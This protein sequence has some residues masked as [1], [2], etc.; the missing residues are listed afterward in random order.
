MALVFDSEMFIFP[1]EKKFDF[2]GMIRNRYNLLKFL[3]KHGVKYKDFLLI[4][5]EEWLI[6][7]C[8]ERLME[9]VGS[10]TLE[11]FVEKTSASFKAIITAKNNIALV[12]KPWSTPLSAISED[13]EG[14]PFHC[15]FMASG[16]TSEKILA[17][18]EKYLKNRPNINI[19]NNSI[20]T[21]LVY[22]AG[23]I[24]SV[25]LSNG[26]IVKGDIFISDVPH[27]ELSRIVKQSNL[28][29]TLS[30]LQRTIPCYEW[31]NGAQFF[32]KDLP[33]KTLGNN[34]PFS[35]GICVG[36]LQAPWKLVYVLQGE[37]FWKNVTLPE[38]CRYVL[39]T[40]YTN[41]LTNGVLFN[42]PVTEC[43][44]E[45]IKEELLKQMQFDERDLI[46]DW[47]LD[48][49]IVFMENKDYEI[50]KDSLRY[51]LA[52]QRKDGSWMLNFSPFYSPIPENMKYSLTSRSQI[53]N[54]FYS[55]DFCKTAKLI[56]TMEK[57]CESGFLAAQAISED[58]NFPSK[59]RL[60][61]SG[62]NTKKYAIF[63]VLDSWLYKLQRAVKKAP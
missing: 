57:A 4:I 25:R 50:Q 38:G 61:F 15:Y 5:K 7:L 52:H 20:V 35:P 58:F 53:K 31:S 8:Y 3:L 47:H 9:Q 63:R 41:H 36:V 17:P 54:F 34:K 40:S 1:K 19:R 49:T 48:D 37:G 23:C 56:P 39:S 14:K 29:A 6:R 11:E 62:Y 24:E 28:S 30:E 33:S 60:P 26:E 21:E 13:T 59:I 46:I 55:G 43:T 22:N 42:K 44:K 2:L 16:P 51:H 32:L 10:K 18:W 12:A 27:M 45:E